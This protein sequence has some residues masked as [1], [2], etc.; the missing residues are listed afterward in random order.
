MVVTSSK[1]ICKICFS[2]YIHFTI[3]MYINSV[4]STQL[5]LTHLTVQWSVDCVR[6][7]FTQKRNRMGLIEKFENGGHKRL[8]TYITF[9]A[10]KDEQNSNITIFS[11]W[12]QPV[13]ILLPLEKFSLHP[14][15]RRICKSSRVRWSNFH[16]WFPKRFRV[17]TNKFWRHR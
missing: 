8:S 16:G 3:L 15:A 5:R 17:S 11:S 12:V 9:L 14:P 10:M 2:T 6:H 13:F 4:N 1:T 7:F